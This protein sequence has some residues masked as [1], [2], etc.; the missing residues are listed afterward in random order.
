M[1]GLLLMYIGAFGVA[2]FGFVGLQWTGSLSEGGGTFRHDFNDL[3]SW[4]QKG[5]PTLT[6]SDGQLYIQSGATAW[7]Y[8]PGADSTWH[9]T[10]SFYAKVDTFGNLRMAYEGLGWLFWVEVRS[11]G[12]VFTNAGSTG[13]VVD[14]EWHL[15]SFQINVN[16]NSWGDA[17]NQHGNFLFDAI[18]KS[19]LT[20]TTLG[21]SGTEM[22]DVK[23][24]A[25]GNVQAHFDFVE[26]TGSIVVPALPTPPS[27]TPTSVGSIKVTCKKGTQ[28]LEGALVKVVDSAGATIKSGTT[29]ADGTVTLTEIPAPVTY[30][31]SATKEGE[32]SPASQNI[33]VTAITTPLPVTFVFSSPVVT[34]GTIIATC[35]KNNVALAGVTVSVGSLSQ[36]SGSDGVATISSIS[37]STYTVTA[38]KTGETTQTKTNIEVSATNTPVSLSFSFDPPS[39]TVGT[40]TIIARDSDN[41]LIQAN[42][43]IVGQNDY[44]N[45]GT[46][47]TSEASLLT[48]TDVP[49]GQFSVIYSTSTTTSLPQT[50]ILSQTN[51]PL[52]VTYTF[53]SNDNNDDN[54]SLFNFSWDWTVMWTNIKNTVEANRQIMLTIGGIMALLSGVM[55]ILPAKRLPVSFG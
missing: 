45:S 40:V 27:I 33:P 6:V 47:S 3:N 50:K 11:G 26:A 2:G 20:A 53:E 42:I 49:Y 51:T 38:S 46:T 48:F 43:Q 12:A 41:A 22:Y 21:A 37:F 52:T 29:A 35:K 16:G 10:V 39:Q 30:T 4:N 28:L 8:L 13:V 32:T 31:V 19:S 23:I 44:V 54:G 34:T 36:T 25:T 1:L 5:L 17:S 18:L 9:F 15:Y 14:H 7:S 55:V 24:V